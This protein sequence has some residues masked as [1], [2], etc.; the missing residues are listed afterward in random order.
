VTVIVEANLGISGRSFLRIIERE[1]IDLVILGTHSSPRPGASSVRVGFTEHFASRQSQRGGV[2]SFEDQRRALHAQA[3]ALLAATDF[4]TLGRAIPY[5]A[6]I[7]RRADLEDPSRRSP[8]Q[9]RG[10]NPPRAERENRELLAQL[11]S[12]VPADRA[13]PLCNRARDYRE[14]R[15]GGSD[16]AGGGTI[17][18]DLICLGSHGRM[19]WR[20]TFSA[21]SPQWRDG[22]ES[23]AVLRVREE[24]L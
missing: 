11:R 10:Q 7:L 1:K 15:C 9:G 19:D 5:A 16:S 20:K 2:P 18:A 21:R 17:N 22:R 14:R 12:L 3:G 4:S 24:R 6:S 8:V 23:P 13:S